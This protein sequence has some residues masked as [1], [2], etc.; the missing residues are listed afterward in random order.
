MKLDKKRSIAF[1]DICDYYDP[2]S[3]SKFQNWIDPVNRESKHDVKSI[4]FA[5]GLVFSFLF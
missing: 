5:E 1:Q 2:S 3:T 4:N